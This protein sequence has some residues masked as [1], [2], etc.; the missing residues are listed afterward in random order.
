MTLDRRSLLKQGALA[1]VL[2][3]GAAAL[4]IANAPQAAAV[5]NMQRLVDWKYN[6]GGGIYTWSYVAPRHYYNLTY[7][8]TFWSRSSSYRASYEGDTV[9]WQYC[10]EGAGGNIVCDW[11]PDTF[12][13]LNHMNWELDSVVVIQVMLNALVEQGYLGGSTIAA[14]GS[15]GNITHYKVGDFQIA[16]GLEVDGVVG[17]ATMS[18]MKAQLGL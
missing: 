13:S 2:T 8:T 12:E 17:P 6:W 11:R 14:D 3:A 18:A 10:E 7:E 1:G 5:S 9:L 16:A 15:F 4:G